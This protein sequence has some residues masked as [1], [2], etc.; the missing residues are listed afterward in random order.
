MLRQPNFKIGWFIPNQIAALTHPYAEIT[1]DDFMGVIQT[2]QNLLAQVENEF[3]IIIDN[4]FVDMP[5]LVSLSQI[6]QSVPYMNH[7]FLRW[8]AVIKPQKLALNV[9]NLPIEKNGETSLKNFADL[10]EAIK[11]LKE[12]VGEVQWQ[13]S[14]GAFFP[15]INLD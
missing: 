5:S 6:K 9:S 13:H 15:N 8:I 14:D 11:F 12:N 1:P 3:H 2:G 7:P 4:R 10:P